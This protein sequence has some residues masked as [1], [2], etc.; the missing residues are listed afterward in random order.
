FSLAALPIYG[1]GQSLIDPD[2]VERRR[3]AFWMMAIYVAAGLGLLVTTAFLGLRRY[4][5]QRGLNMPKKM[6]AAWLTAGGVLT[7]VL[8][9]VGALLPR[10]DAE[11]SVLDLAPAKS[12]TRDASDFAMKDGEGGKGE[13][14]VGEQ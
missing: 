5:R 9:V 1:L 10:P 6:T 12:E 11:Y 4:L 8:L 7:L 3:H 2:D 13:G 14:R